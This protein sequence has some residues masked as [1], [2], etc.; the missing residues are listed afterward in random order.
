MFARFGFLVAVVFCGCESS[1]EAEKKNTSTEAHKVQFIGVWASY[2][3]PDEELYLGKKRWIFSRN[4]PGRRTIEGN[5]DF[6]ETHEMSCVRD[7]VLSATRDRI[8]GTALKQFD[9]IR[10]ILIREN[11][12]LRIES[13]GSSKCELNGMYRYAGDQTPSKGYRDIVD[14]GQTSF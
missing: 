9:E 8:A 1:G 12:L 14:W 10:L 5:V 3:S 11:D 6:E 2:E 7:V 13:V 4:L